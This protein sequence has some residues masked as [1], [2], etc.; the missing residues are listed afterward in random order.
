MW[1]RRILKDNAKLALRGR[2]WTTFLACLLTYLISDLFSIVQSISQRNLE[3]AA[4]SPRI[5]YAEVA[6]RLGQQSA[7]SL[8]SLAYMVF[9]GIPLMIGIARFFVHNRFGETNV[10]TVFSGF[11]RNYGNGVGAMFVT[12]LFICLWSILL[13]IPGIYK[14][15][16]Y[17]MVPYILTDNPNLPGARVREISRAMTD[18]QKGAIFV[19]NLSFIGWCL[20]PVIPG[21]IV[22]WAFSRA[23]GT[24]LAGFLMIFVYPYIYATT[25]ELYIFLRDRVLQ[26]G[27]ALPEEFGLVPPPA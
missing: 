16:Q 7:L 17:S 3:R 4:S 5:D 19:L 9:V 23:L 15:L 20:L 11:R 22:G 8:I 14:A 27:R 18:G 1:S 13:I 2:Y 10:D 25:A 21:V 6:G 12:G 26:S 24:L